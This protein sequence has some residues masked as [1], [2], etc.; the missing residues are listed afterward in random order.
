MPE[1]P[2]ACT[3][4]PADLARRRAALT[5]LR[6]SAA[7]VQSIDDGLVLRFAAQPGL[8]PR[9][10][11]VIDLERQCCR[12]LRFR[13][14]VAPDGGAITLTVTGPPGTCEFLAHELGLEPRR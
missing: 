9:L 8:L 2:L 4:Q 6:S 11:E 5:V 12:F 7:D 14:D 13:L 1:L 3:L 10:A